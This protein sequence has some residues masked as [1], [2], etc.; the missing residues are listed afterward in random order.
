MPKDNESTKWLYEQLK[1]KG[2]NVG[3]DQAEFDNLM[4]NNKASREWAYKTAMSAGLNVG[5]DQ[6]EFDNL[7][8]P[9]Q[10]T[11]V[12]RKKPANGTQKSTEETAW[13]PTM[14]EKLAMN[15]R[16]NAIGR[17]AQRTMDD[18]NTHID[19]LNE[20]G[21]TL[22]DGHTVNSGYRFNPDSKKME[23]TYLTPT[24]ER[25]FNKTAADAASKEYRDAVDMTVGG[26][27][28]RAQ[29]RLQELK[30]KAAAR[31]QELHD[32]WEQD[33]KN[34]TA[35]LAAV[36]ARDTY[37]PSIQ[38]DH[39]FRALQA[40]IHQTE[41][42]IKTLNEQKDRENGVDV[43]FWRGFMRT[44]GDLRSWDFGIND[45]LD[46]M[47]MLHAQDKDRPHTE[48]EKAA[49]QDMMRA[50][51]EYQQT[52]AM[53]GG[54]ASF[55][56]RAGM[57]T[58][59]MPS[60]MLDFALTGGGYEGINVAS[61]VAG[62]AATKALGKEAVKSMAE[63]GFKTYIKNN[64]LKGLGQE[65]ANWTIKALGTTTDE[66]LIRAPLMTNTVQA[67]DTAADIINRKLG[68]VT[69]DENGNYDFT[70]DKTWGS[71]IWQGEANSIVENYSEMFG[72]HLPEVASLKNLGKLA[73]VIGAKRLS[74][75]LSRANAGAL[76][77]ITDTTRRIFGQMG[78]SDYL[79]EVSE[80]YYGQLWRTMFNLDDAYQQNADGTRT[81]LFATKQFHGDI[82][83][84]MALSMEL[85]GAGKT[86]MSA[87]GYLS[88]KHDVNKA[89]AMASEL[90]TPDVWE[91]LRSVID[92]ATND[93][94]GD[95]AEEIM[96]DKELT[97]EEKAAVLNYM[98][99]SLYLRGVN[100][101]ELVKSRGGE[102]DENIQRAND[103]YIDGYNAATDE[104]KQNAKNMYDLQRQKAE[105]ILSPETL[106]EIDNDPMGALQQLGDDEEA[107]HAIIDYINAKQVYD[108]MIQ[109][110]RDDIDSRIEQ[111]NTMIDSRVNR[112]TGAIQGVTMKVQDDEGKDR[113]AYVLEGN[114]VML[115][116]GTGIDHDNSDE[117][118]V[119]RD[120]ATGAIEMVSPDAILSMEQPVD[121]ELEKQTAAEAIRQQF[122]G[123]AAN[124][125]DGVLPFN[126]GDTYTLTDENGQQSQIQIVPNQDG[127]V[128]NGD[129]TVNVSSDGGVT[130]V[131]MS[132]DDIQ[133]MSDATNRTRVLQ[134]EQQREAER[135]E[136]AQPEYSLNTEVTLRDEAGNAVRGSITSDMNEDGQYEVYT[137]NPINGRKVNLFTAD[138]L[139]ALNYE[140]PEQADGNNDGQN[141]PENGNIGQENILAP[142]ATNE[143]QVQTEAVVQQQ[144][145]SALER[146]PKD[147]K[148]EPV[149][150]QTDADTAWDAIVEQSEGDEATAKAVADSMV[151]DKEAEL[152]KIEKAKP[153][154]GTT[155]AEKIAAERE[156]KNAVEQA[157]ATLAHWQKIAQTAERRRQVAM[158]EQARAAAETARLRR[159]QEETERAEREEAD[160]IRREA[161]NGVPDII[162][163]KPQDARARGFR[164]VNGEKVDRQQPLQAKHGKEVQVKFDDKNIP[165]GRV[166]L[167]EAEQLQP[168]HVNGRRNPLHFIDE[169]QPKERNDEAS[170]ISARNIAANIRP[171]E[172][173]S[174][175]TAY[176]GAPTVNARGEVIQGNNRSAALREMWAG[177]PEQ[178]AKYKQY[179]AAH[180]AD[181]GLTP[182]DVEAMQHPVLVNMIDVAD[183]DAITL[184]Q[185]VAQD[186]ESGGVERIKPKN[187]VQKMGGNMRSYANLL[188]KS[189]DDEMSFAELVDRNG[190]DVLKWM[191]QKGYIT[192]TQYKSAFDSKGNLTA[193]AKNDLKGIMY[194][195]IFQNGN[196]HL[197]EMFGALPVKAQKAI[198]ATAYRDY[199][200]PNAERMNMELQ[201]SISAYYAL[202]QMPE[203]ANA[204][205][206]KEAR[207]AAEAWKRLLALDDVTGESYLPSERYS[208]FA[209]LLATMYKGQTQ[210]FIQNTFKNIYD[211][212][213]GTQEE[214]LFETPDNTPRTL[215]EAINEAINSLSDELL[216]NGNFI[217]NGQRRNNVL[218]G[219]S[220]AGQ[221]GRQ[222]GTGSPETGE[223]VENGDA[224][225]DRSGGTESDSGEG[226]IQRPAERSDNPRAENDSTGKQEYTL[227]DKKSG[228]GEQFYQD[229]TGNIDLAHIPDEVFEQIG[230]T[231]APFRLTPGMILHVLNSHGK[232]LGVS[233]VDET[234][235]FILDVMNNFDHVRLGYDGALIFSVEN[236]RRRTGKRAITILINSDNGQFYGLKSSG[237]EAVNGLNK[238]P[239]LWE[240]GAK[241]S[242]SSADAAT[243]SVPTGKSSLSG[244]QSGS[245]S[246]QSKDL[247]NKYSPSSSDRHLAEHS[248]SVPDLLPTQGEKGFSKE[249][250]RR[251][252]TA[253][254]PAGTAEASQE[255]EQSGTPVSSS[256][257]NAPTTSQ[258]S[259]ETPVKTEPQQPNNAVSTGS[260]LSE[261][262]EGGITHSEPNGEPTVSESKDSE[263]SPIINGLGEKIAEEE[264]K[265]DTNPT[266]AQKEAGNYKKGHVRI[267]QF[268][269]SIEQPKGSVRSGVDASG[270]KWETTMQNTYG[271]IRGTEGVDGDHID[272]F[273]TNDIDGWN[274]R[275]VYIVD[276]YN[277]DG[278]FDEHKVMLGFNDEAD[279]QDAYLSNYEKGWENKRKLVMTSVNLPDFEKWINSSHRK[280]KP[281][282]EYQSVNGDQKTISPADR[283]TEITNRMSELKKQADEAHGRSDIFEEARLIAE[284]NELYAELRRLQQS[285]K[286][287]DA[288]SKP[289]NVEQAQNELE[290]E[291]QPVQTDGYTVERRYHKKNGTY[292]NAVKFTE[293][294]PRERFLELKK[295]VKDFGG[296]YSSF[297][298]G[299]F[300]FGNEEDAHRFAHA[301]LDK[302]GEELEDAKPLS[303]AD[304]RKAS[305]TEPK[306][307]D[308][309]GLMEEI[310]E[311]GEAKLSDHVISQPKKRQ[312]DNNS[313]ASEDVKTVNPSGNRLVTDERY[314]ELKKRMKAKLG[315]LNVGI[316]PEIIAIGAEMAVYHIEKGARKFADYAKAMIADMGDVI[317]PYLKSFY[318]AVRDMPEAI[319][320]GLVDDMSAYDEVRSFDVANFDKQNVDALATAE[321]VVQEQ[322][323]NRQTD[324]AKEKLINKRNEQRRNEDEQT[325]ANTEAIASKAETIADEAER[326]IENA[327][328]EQQINEAVETI[329]KQIEEV[330]K[331]LALLGYYEADPVEKDFNEAYG[332]M[333]NAEKKAAK[334][335]SS[336]AK[337]L[338][339]DLG[340]ENEPISDNKGKQRKGYFS[341]SNIA[342][343][344]G[345]IYIN[346][347]LGN[348]RELE[349]VLQ[350]DPDKGDNL[351]YMGGYMRIQNNQPQAGEQRWSN[352]VWLNRDDT[353]QSVL[354]RVRQ[355]IKY[356]APGFVLPAQKD[357]SV[358]DKSQP[359]AKKINKKGVSLHIEGSLFDD[360]FN[361][362]ATD[363]EQNNSNRNENEV[364]LQTGTGTTERERGH[365]PQQDEPVGTGAEAQAE[366]PDGRG[367]DR[368]DTAHSRSDEERGRSVSRTPESQQSI[369]EPKNTRNNHLERGE[370]HTPTSVDA[371]IDANIKA[372]ELSQQLMQSGET[373]TPEQMKVLRK[374]SGWG[375]LGKAFSDTSTS[376]KL[377]DLLG[378]EGYEQ[379]VMSANSAY[380]TPAYVVDTLWDIAEQMGFKGGNILEGSAGIG[381][382]LGQM[383]VR[384]SERSDIQAVEID[385]TSGTILS[386]LYP[387]A[388]VDI[389]GFE[390]TRIP[391]GSVDL[392]I[393]N[394]PFV[395][396][397]RVDDTTGDKDLSKKFHNIHDFCIAKNVRKLREGGI[398]IFISSNGTLDNS[399]K[400]RDW[401]VNEGG[402]DFVGA[403]RMNNRTFG[404]TPVTSDIIVIR[405]R[406]NGQKSP[407]AIDVSTVSGERTAEYDTGDTRKVKGQEV[408][409]VKQLAMDYNRYFI[410]HPENMAGDM[411]FA[412]EEGDTYRPTSKGLY[413]A[414]G[415]DQEKMLAD[416]VDSFAGKD[417]SSEAVTDNTSDPRNPRGYVM[418]AS[419]DGKK[420][421]EMYVK[422]DKLV[423]A[424]AGG[425]YPLQ[426][427]ANKVKG[428]TKVECFNAYSA[429]KTALADVLEYQT[430]NESDKGLKPLLDRLNKAYDDFVAT[431]GHFN[432]NTAIAFLRNDVDYPNVFSLE[433]YEEIATPSGERKQKFGKTDVFS[434]RVVEKEK[435]PTPTNVKDGIIASM[436][437]FGR[438]D[439]PYI[440]G[441]LGEDVEEVK[442]DIIENG[443]GFEDPL[444]KQ[445]EVSYQYLSGN[446]R[447]KLRQAQENNENGVYD[448]NI[449]AL[450]DVLPMDIPAHLIDFTLGSSWVDPKLYEE[451]VKERT[452][453]EV[454]FT[455]AGGTWFMK[456][457]D[458]GLNVEKNR[459]MGVYSER[460]KRTIMGHTL[461]E[462]AIQN[463]TI[464]VSQTYRLHDGT[465]ETE[466]DK[467]A[468]QACSNR[469]DEIRQDFKE[470][471]RFK[472]QNDADIS[473]RM[474]RVYNDTFNN[475]V[476]MS[477]PDDFVPEYFGGAS[478]KFQM[479]SHQGKAIVRGTMQPLMLAHEVGTG[480]TFTL[481]S[482]AMEM[483]RLGTARKPMI[484]VQNATVGQFVASA[485]EL[486]PNAKIL[487]LEEA[488]R[489][490]EGRKNFYAKIRYNDWDMIVVPQSTFDFIPDSEER[491]MS[492]IQDK[493]EEKML[494][495]EQMKD[496]D[497]NGKSVI[498][499]QAER[500]IEELQVQLAELTGETSKKRSAS[501]QKKRAVALQNAEVKAKEMLDRA[502]DDVENFDDMGI[503]ALLIDEAHE[504][505]HLG[506]ATAM[507][508]GVKGVDP[509][510]SKKSQGLF[511]KVQA[512]LEKN[513]GRNVIFA[514]GTPI[515]NTAAEIWTF[516]RYLMPVDM[517]KEYGIYYFDDFVRNFGNIQQMLEFSTNGKYK[518][519]NR[520]AGYVNLPELV[521]IWLGVADIVRTRDAGGVND[522]IPGME[523]NKAQDIYLPQ[524]RALRSIM[525]FVKSELEKFENMSG[526]EKKA[527]S[528]IPLTMFGIAK[529][530]AVDARL[531]QADAEDDPR[532]KTNEAVR[533]TLRSLK[534]TAD[535][536]GTVA[537]FADNYQNKQSGF[538]LYEDIR[539][540]LIAAGVPSEQIVVMR[541]GM[542]VK[543]K[544][545]IFDKV[546]RGDVRVILGSTFTL[547]TGVNIQE[548]LHTLIHLDAPNRPMDYTQRNGRIL[549]QG[550]LHRVMGKPVRVLRFGV[551]DSLD[552][553][554][555]QRLKTKGAI[556]DSIMNGKQFIADSMSNRVLEEDEDVFGDVVA[557]LSG[558]EYALLKNN[559]EKNVRKYESRKKQWEADQTYIHNAKPKL[560]ALI[561][562][563]ETR[564]KEQQKYLDAVKKSFPNG[565]FES[566]TIGKQ[567]FKSVDDMA[568]FI[569]GYNKTILDA[570]KKMKEGGNTAEE[571]HNL[572]VSLGDYTFK[573][574]TVL[575]RET[576][577][578]GGQLF[579]EIHRNMTY[580]CPELGLTDVP[581]HQSL[582]RN[583]ID[584]IVTNV[585]TGK[586]FAERVDAAERSAEHNRSELEQLQSRENKPFEYEDE[587]KQAHEKLKEYSE[588]MKKEMAEKEA[589]YAEMDASVDVAE[590]ITNIDDDDVLYRIDNFTTN[591]E[592]ANDLFR[593]VDDEGEIERLN[594]EPTIKVY[595]AMSLVDGKLYPPMSKKIGT[596]N[597]R[598]SQA[599]S[600]FGQWEVSDERPQLVEKEGAHKNHIYI[601]KDNGK[602]LWVAYNPYFHTSR[603]PLNDQFAEAYQRP[604][605]VTVEVEVPE[606]ELTSGYQADG[607]KDPVGETKWNAG[608]VNRQLSGDK[609]RKVI[610]SRWMRPVRIVPDSEVA[611][612]ISELIEGENVAIPDNTVT[613]SLLEELKKLGVKIVDGINK[614]RKKSP[615]MQRSGEGT[616]TDDELSLVND[617]VAKLTGKSTRTSRQRREFAERERERMAGRVQELAEKLHLDNVDI[618]TDASMLNGRRARAKGFYSRSTG[619]ITIVIPNHSNIFDVEQTLLHE[620]VAHYGL[621]Q[622]FGEH[623]DT[624]LWNVY[625]NADIEVRQRITEL[626]SLN[627][628]DY[629]TATEEYLASLAENT[630]FENINASWW[631]KI[632][633]LFLRMLHKIGFENFSGV[634]LSDNEL[635]Y[636][637]WRSYENLKE[638][639]RYRSILGEAADVA[640]Q[641][642]LKVGNYAENSLIKTRR[643][644]EVNVDD[645]ENVNRKFNE[646]LEGLTEENKDSVTLSLGRP[647]PILRAAGVEDKPMKLYGNKVIKKMKKHGFKLEELRNLPEAVANPITVFKNYGKDGNRSILTELKTEQGNFLVTLTLGEGHDVD[648]NVVTSV[649]GKGES[650]IIDWIKRGFTTYINKEKALNYLH[651]SALKAVTS[652]NQELSSAANIV[653]NFENPNISEENLLYRE[654]DD[655][656]E[657]LNKS[658]Q[659]EYDL[660]TLSTAFKFTEAAQAGKGEITEEEAN[661][662]IKKLTK[663]ADKAESRAKT[664]SGEDLFRDN[665]EDASAIYEKGV[666]NTLLHRLSEGWYDYL[667][668][669]RV[670]QDALQKAMGRK[671][672]DFE[673]VLLNALHKT[674]V[675]KAQWDSLKKK[676][677]DP[678]ANSLAKVVDGKKTF[679]GEKLTQDGVEIYLNCK[680]GLERNDKFAMR[681][682]EQMRDERI[683][684]ADAELSKEEHDAKNAMNKA[685]KRADQHLQDGEIDEAKHDQ[686]VN[687][688]KDEYYKSIAEANDAHEKAVKE[689]E[690]NVTKDYQKNRE[691]DY[692]GLTEIFDPEGEAGYTNAELEDMAR[693]Y[694]ADMEQAVPKQELNDLWDKIHK[695]NAYSLKKSY[696]S[697]LISK[698]TYDSTKN[699]FDYYVPLRGFNKETA[700]DVY[701]YITESDIPVEQVMKHAG[702]R[703]SRATN[704][705]A[706][707]MN[708]GHSSI[709]SG[710]RNLV[711][712]KL[713]NLA[714]NADNDLLTVG[715]QW[716]EDDGMGGWIPVQEPP[717][718]D[719]M[720]AKEAREVV[721]QFE[722]NMKER[723]K[724]GE[725]RRMRKDVSLP[726]RI[727]GKRAE[728]EHGVRV[729]RNGQEYV[730]WINGNPKAA[731]AIN[732]ILNPETERGWLLDHIH[733]LNRFVSKN[734]TSLRP[735]FLLSN[736][737]RDILSSNMVG[738]VK[739]GLK[740]TR[741]F[742]KFVKDNLSIV[743]IKGQ[744]AGMMRGIYALYYRYN[745]GTLDMDDKRDRYFK[746][747]MEHVGETGY[748]QMW[749]IDDYEKQIRRTLNKDT[750]KEKFRDG[751]QALGDAV[752]FVNR[753]IENVCRFAAYMASRES[754]MSVL[755]SIADAKEASVN[756]N[757]K[758]SG[759]MGN[760]AARA[761]FMFLNP[762]IQGFMQHNKLLMKYPKRMLAI[763]GGLIALGV[764]VGLINSFIW[765]GDDDDDDKDTEDDYFNINPFV[766]RNNI[767]LRVG[768]HEYAKIDLPQELRPWYGL[769]EIAYAAMTGH[770]KYD[771]VGVELFSQLTQTIPL[772]P[773]TGNTILDPDE[774]FGVGIIRNLTGVTSLG[775]ITDAY[776]FDKDYAGNKITKANEYNKL[777]PEWKRAG[778]GTSSL[779]IGTTKMLNGLT[780]GN[781]YK[782]GLVDLNPSR[783]EHV[784]TSMLGGRIE[785][786]KQLWTTGQGL[787]SKDED[788]RNNMRN[789]PF[790]STSY[791]NTDNSYNRDYRLNNEF[792]WY[793]HEFEQAW[794]EYNGLKNDKKNVF[795]KAEEFDAFIQTPEYKI[796]RR[797]KKY[798]RLLKKQLEK[799]S[800]ETDDDK[801]KEINDKITE[802]KKDAVEEMQRISK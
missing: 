99:R 309:I 499:R 172:I 101:A 647:S 615:V 83:G 611:Q 556:A 67:G 260:S 358:K 512:V 134:S 705:I 236:G 25:T 310:K 760:D 157:K 65:A 408:P 143:Q 14:K 762:A 16:L 517:M 479:R 659:D 574:K 92:M 270:N 668:S 421:G 3:K 613:P 378:A 697:G 688:A 531:V 29:N 465:T 432:K 537:I 502:T 560:K 60:F 627:G 775:S 45:M 588:L 486:Y 415:K 274:G 637:L 554:A 776:L 177:Q 428:H 607:A 779:M 709:V 433:K 376:R 694:V 234:I 412:F 452:G 386:L 15:A 6:A 551:E 364:H 671:L 540:K 524:T 176:T 76:G 411:R 792:D 634:T 350:L 589:K 418:D 227:S 48:Q 347:P 164:R 672:D 670:L 165:A 472:M 209:I 727:V 287:T 40:A 752:E 299:G 18:F 110:V 294:M 328:D 692:S 315:Q 488:D 2:Y 361:E 218:A 751:W 714:L 64:G 546:N 78:V 712:Q 210:M 362:N 690:N 201:D 724:N 793:Q 753:G 770:M 20:Y 719:G 800:D 120:A 510:Y 196:T 283:A 149:Y 504:Y 466:V 198:L 708:M 331:Q 541:S 742:D 746:E 370:N 57:M 11:S 633:E 252:T 620:A 271:Y 265:V 654:S 636:I 674:S 458:Y 598:I 220:A 34:N 79:G 281:F 24:G 185:F 782:K 729:K 163:D 516:M 304:T 191:Q 393:T 204:K 290:T 592:E 247:N 701:D 657:S 150:E 212:V 726:I 704:L 100:L 221:E 616:L 591:E 651:H 239:L 254:Q 538:N 576:A 202:S 679:R 722:E 72:T 570:S 80:E 354:D 190:M 28:R 356:H 496:A 528:H 449:K 121:P 19:N 548:R 320:N 233:S 129:G 337:R 608:P 590:N 436:F 336:L 483:R 626:A 146:I 630:N 161:L 717:I 565:T 414:K 112:A 756:F 658:W 391:N 427:N 586:D 514:T 189:T 605:L 341:Y 523:G 587:L 135:L 199:D 61:R 802:I 313:S 623:F 755:Q 159:E 402:S 545:E 716:Y 451:Y 127:I 768:Q 536:K 759:A 736:L 405:K 723:E 181:F 94:V 10:Q 278:T 74:G 718:R 568:D 461:I 41:E 796:Y 207:I 557:Q 275:R 147:D 182:E 791:I 288:M 377:Q 21:K 507:Q 438:I 573:V 70:N 778:R 555:Y 749:S 739:Y 643:V 228:N 390:Q 606:S 790:V 208:N 443:Y 128:D 406:V 197:E 543:K 396:G 474:E 330:N 582:L 66:L 689:A 566:I 369:T 676:Y 23:R 628:W 609:K 521:R 492:F 439:V 581:V 455:A 721:E 476:P 332:Y 232:E 595:R 360:L 720:T 618:V 22:G 740:Y 441:Q 200:S 409:V 423:I 307:I 95:V 167:I 321:M 279:A 141:I 711:K 642:E 585:I 682:A 44:A 520:F 464:T 660:R 297:G 748:S 316:D 77:G 737:K 156:R 580:S 741:M 249:V 206:Y 771:N 59:Y 253:K 365:E 158:A 1:S 126:Q 205:N 603:N 646:E 160:R 508:R 527:N 435:E 619:R 437:K 593:V 686:L 285:S 446:V 781:D 787:T 691:R 683:K 345:E 51:H 707:M 69:V 116:D 687:E 273:L 675:D 363:V 277:E 166:S 13:K 767:V 526:K 596:G 460:F 298:K 457:P 229:A 138:E 243:A 529:A 153:K 777:D 511:L 468:T 346:L 401:I 754:G 571:T 119:I 456:A 344:G 539:N 37:V 180:A 399:K 49:N 183:D 97:G 368:R 730:V 561:E 597:N 12:P 289:A 639:G 648:F 434:K 300:I 96:A 604:N 533:Q 734:V 224:S 359:K 272:V 493:I 463:K 715:N 699:M 84:G 131:P 610:L 250:Y 137:E 475:Y 255:T 58:G 109:R 743:D 262:V 54:N 698:Q 122:A 327:T 732:G 203:F 403:F 503:D 450:Q 662:Q 52:E 56:N 82:W 306:Q 398:G 664:D 757:R 241:E 462:A 735:N 761:V 338:A 710:D 410:E 381:N 744:N 624:F 519:N 774:S 352:N 317:R 375:G 532:S 678:L 766:R 248:E 117:S 673:N 242:S 106:A 497:P 772:N 4:R 572:S 339:K 798:D 484:V 91:P 684:K 385:G 293:Q 118:I 162:D 348:N 788:E 351:H 558:S 387:D 384:I 269:V 75:V 380:Y 453:I 417:W 33:Y 394:V 407:Y 238:R 125:I 27:I 266:E 667:R 98:E 631:S 123:E 725:V 367:V 5:K 750:A 494:V 666:A 467:E 641:H 444:T 217:Y 53:Y 559:A 789:Y 36:L 93:N 326:N 88:M 292:I 731:Q 400:L 251:H 215:V 113:R 584:D 235:R 564:A 230:Y 296:Y 547:G 562:Q 425:Y 349:I 471:A 374:F 780:G 635:R 404:G 797:F 152:K 343:A 600:E 179:L 314:E 552:V 38:S 495:L 263:K 490:A 549:R 63:Q 544:L 8:A 194:Q 522:K 656:E 171:E 469:I 480:K 454:K 491:Q 372:I 211:L 216:L 373:A 429:I 282:A 305:D 71:A 303:L 383:P 579:S 578:G 226:N 319:D 302:S 308:V 389:Q 192:S 617:P 178:A 324:E 594:S 447:E 280:T 323:A 268:D 625:E 681:D 416:F 184:G 335:A 261:S 39:T 267:G 225:A 169:A 786:F 318:N 498:T 706:T 653:K 553:T 357:V 85:M 563:S 612:R 154:G 222:G 132:K 629:P 448:N 301:V 322:E 663:Q 650:N 728:N 785:F 42:Q 124:R 170:V 342:P 632:K 645:I 550:N 652:S 90:L 140:Q 599:P 47:T 481:I 62:K 530:A 430:N 397:L 601:V 661:D 700:N 276:Q 240:R 46:A 426:V 43:G 477:I 193:E 769:G 669:V 17:S 295:R 783:L 237:Y 68:D 7:V 764:I 745:K 485:K 382:I 518:E 525:N 111:S 35:P 442:H 431:Y 482:T 86:T 353:Y 801:R 259:S 108:G 422:D 104:E 325:A 148:G 145:P 713:L 649:F 773:I 655:A 139:N 738:F 784:A 505:K 445:M 424:S 602:G 622:L 340:I 459:S 102:Q 244:E 763:D 258:I 567:T 395:T 333:R 291:Q 640:K 515:S 758:G 487:T 245:A 509:S 87:A 312:E 9:R 55:W 583:A 644:A 188:L 489:S 677:I 284:S 81:N 535:Y 195:S 133:F 419:A 73:N 513:N 105:Q 695:I 733:K 379:A 30:D 478:H 246:H 685:I 26:Q 500:E 142:T 621:R 175:V 680:H 155:V 765:G 213:Q 703:T 693:Q 130:V 223:R 371:R 569:K 329:D 501:N 473:A 173:T 257:V 542:T 577:R 795:E 534:E 355:Q 334:D 413:P 506:F 264:K 151:A 286:T 388:K 665:D 136:Q 168:S 231:K 696:E 187:I 575:S 114:L 366:R 440:A 311:K 614:G 799:L 115:D 420:L 32:K 50:I 219:G 31:Q 747:F 174:S 638:P 702:G 256:M 186:T 144:H 103:S 89:D 107:N 794:H 392:A 214:T 470:W